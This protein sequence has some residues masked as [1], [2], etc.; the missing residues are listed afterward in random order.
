MPNDKG[1]GLA[2][3]AELFLRAL[4]RRFAVQLLLV[5]ISGGFLQGRPWPSVTDLCTDVLVMRP[6]DDPLF[7]F[8]LTLR[9][10]AQQLAALAEYPMPVFARFA[11]RAVVETAHRALGDQRFAAVHIFRL[12]MAPFAEPLLGSVPAVLDLD[13]D[14]RRTALSLAGLAR[15]QGNLAEAA[16]QEAEAAKLA[17]FE[18]EWAT[19][20]S[21]V[22]LAGPDDATRAASRLRDVEATC[23]PNAV[24]VPKAFPPPPATGPFTLLFVGSMGYSPNH[25]AAAFLAQ[26]VLPRLRQRTSAAVRLVLAGSHP[27]A[28]L[29]ALASLPEVEVTGWV[30]DLVP[31][32]AACHAVAAPLRAG[33]GTRI[34]ILEA[35]AHGRPVVATPLGAEGIA[36]RNGEHLLLAESADELAAAVCRLIEA[37]ALGCA[38]A[39]R[40]RGLVSRAYE[41]QGVVRRIE[42]LLP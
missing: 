1:N 30:D 38:L 6:E 4:T 20:F 8:I 5:P 33:G 35:F 34:K 39:R 29:Q 31:L 10:S 9:D 14:E 36:A 41:R 26:E 18:A 7:G 40:A 3:R 2:M 22:C 12:Y 32:Y 16:F 11:R 27:D 42:R 17:R 28:S 23:I 37:P 21:T 19:R 13:D 15:H 25:D 24:T